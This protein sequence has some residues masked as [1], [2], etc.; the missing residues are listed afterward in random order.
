MC[1]VAEQLVEDND[2]VRLEKDAPLRLI[3]RT[4]Q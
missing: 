3:P 2:P 1:V 4:K